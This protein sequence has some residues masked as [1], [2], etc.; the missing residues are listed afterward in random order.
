MKLP[1]LI[2]LLFF[3]ILVLI[4]LS[5][6]KLA[7]E[8]TKIRKEIQTNQKEEI[9]NRLSLFGEVKYHYH[10]YIGGLPKYTLTIL[11]ELDNV[12]EPIF[13]TVEQEKE[14]NEFKLETSHKLYSESYGTG[15][16]NSLLQTLNKTDYEVTVDNTYDYFVTL[17]IKTKRICYKEELFIRIS[18]ICTLFE[19]YYQIENEEQEGLSFVL[20]RPLRNSRNVTIT[21]DLEEID[22][23]EIGL[24]DW[25]EEVES[26]QLNHKDT[27]ESC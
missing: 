19:E 25:L 7:E 3:V 10:P 4:Y 24:S 16:F 5:V 13:V 17:N 27:K 9:I 14:S 12:T 22:S 15:K 8:Q 20:D 11:N 2:L 21:G 18:N 1:L 6:R 26:G 23:E